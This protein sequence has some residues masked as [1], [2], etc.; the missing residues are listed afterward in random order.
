MRL[1]NV[2][3][4]K[5]RACSFIAL[6]IH[7][8]VACWQFNRRPLYLRRSVAVKFI[9]KRFLLSSSFCRMLSIDNINFTINKIIFNKKF[10]WDLVYLVESSYFSAS[11]NYFWWR[12][13]RGIHL[14]LIRTQQYSSFSEHSL[15]LVGYFALILFHTSAMLTLDSVYAVLFIN[16]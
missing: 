13:S 2:T 8:T 12:A 15:N 4:Y 3:F 9:K 1:W 10:F 6:F 14:I 7:C 11:V 16:I 5:I